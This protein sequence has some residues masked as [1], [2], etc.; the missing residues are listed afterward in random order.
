[1]WMLMERA[2]GAR[3]ELHAHDHELCAV[4]EHLPAHAFAGLV[5]GNVGCRNE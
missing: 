3:L 4:A 1:M 2:D 5:P